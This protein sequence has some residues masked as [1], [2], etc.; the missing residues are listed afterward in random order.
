M[1][2]GELD[3]ARARLDA[4]ALAVLVTHAV[5]FGG[6]RTDA[7]ALADITVD[8]DGVRMAR[9]AGRTGERGWWWFRVPDSGPIVRDLERYT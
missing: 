9:V 4:D 3:D 6:A 5:S 7:L 1:R 2:A 8:D